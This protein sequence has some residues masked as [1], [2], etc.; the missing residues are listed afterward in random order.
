MPLNNLKWNSA[1]GAS[2][3]F[4]LV[5]AFAYGPYFLYAPLPDVQQDSYIY[6][7]AAGL[8]RDGVI[9]FPK[10]T[11]DVPVGHPVFV[12][13]VKSVT[14]KTGDVIVVQN[15]LF[16]ASCVYA[17]FCFGK[18]N[19]AYAWV[20]AIALSLYS[21]DNFTM[22]L[23]TSLYS[24]C[25]Y[26]TLLIF[27]AARLV[28]FFTEKDPA[29][30][31]ALVFSLLLPGLV[32]PNGI[33]AFFIVGLLAVFIWQQKFPVKYWYSLAGSLAATMLLWSGVNYYFKGI[34]LPSDPYRI[35]LVMER[36]KKAREWNNP[37][38][39]SKSHKNRSTLFIENIT[40]I[41]QTKPSFYFTFINDRY[42]YLYE[43]P[44][45]AD[46]EQKLF[47]RFKVDSAAPLL[48]SYLFGEFMDP[49]T[50]PTTVKQLANLQSPQKSKWMFL[51][52]ITY[53]VFDV[54]FW[55]YLWVVAFCIAGIWLLTAIFLLKKGNEVHYLLFSLFSM[56]FVSVVVVT[57]GHGG[58]QA[59]YPHITEPF[60]FLTV[61]LTL[62]QIT[63][64]FLP[65][66][67]S[68]NA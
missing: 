23:N 30:L 18:L 64:T 42:N 20:A 68:A 10:F 56:H 65:K 24:E 21:I 47:N 63:S 46:S 26:S 36:N 6:F 9:P 44:M 16:I 61:L 25:L 2:L 12:W 55:N 39:H 32:R 19:K 59:R 28:V 38:G 15:L 11:V 52:H 33:Y 35:A 7:W 22:R 29:S 40:S 31:I 54:L 51:N 8:I 14:G 48:K 4:G 13:A 49:T 37:E 66:N 57:I 3:L 50:K 34:F 53:R 5:Y 58:F 60:L 43:K 45:Y 17:I 27:I 62:Y 41:S 1:W 67:S